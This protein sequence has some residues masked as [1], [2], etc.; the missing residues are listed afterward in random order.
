MMNRFQTWLSNSTRAAT[1][2]FLEFLRDRPEY[3]RAF[4]T[5]CP[6]LD[7]RETFAGLVAAALKSA[8]AHDDGGATAGAYTRPLFSST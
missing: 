7:A 5:R 6:S 2:W 1:Q 3:I 8:V 4:L